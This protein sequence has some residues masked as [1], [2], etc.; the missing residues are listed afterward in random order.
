M[1]ILLCFLSRWIWSPRNLFVAFTV[2]LGAQSAAAAPLT[3]ICY[4][5]GA[6]LPNF[7]LNGT[8][9][10]DG[11]SLLVTPNDFTK[12]ASIMYI[13]KFPVTG[14][15]H[16]RL[17]VN[18][19]T[20]DIGPLA[21]ADGM[22]FVMHND[23]D[24][25]RALGDEGYA[26]GYGGDALGEEIS[27]SVV[28]EFDT[29]QNSEFT[30]AENDANHIGVMLNGDEQDHAALYNPP[31]TMQENTFYVW[32]DYIPYDGINPNLLVYV[33][34]DSTKPGTANIE[35]ILDLESV[36]GSQ[37]FYM[38]FT[39][40]T[41]GQRS[42]HEILEFFATN[43]GT[44][45]AAC[46]VDDDSCFGHP[47]GEL[48]DP[49]RHVCAQ[50]IATD[51]SQ[52][53]QDTP[54]CDMSGS[55]NLCADACDADF[56]EP[57]TNPCAYG[58]L[59]VCAFSGPAAGSCIVCDGNF[60]DTGGSGID[61]PC[62]EGA[63]TCTASGWCSFCAL[64]E[65]CPAEVC[66][67]TTGECVACDG[68]YAEPTTFPCPVATLPVC[69]EGT[70]HACDGDLDSGSLFE[71]SNQDLPYCE[72]SSGA[73]VACLDNTHCS[74]IT[75]YCNTTGYVC[76]ACAGD[77]TPWCTNPDAPQC[78]T[79]GS[80]VECVDSGDCVG[81][82]PACNGDHSCVQCIDDSTCSGET[83]ICD[84]PNNACVQCIDGGDCS[85]GTPV[86]TVDNMCVQC[87]DSDDCSGDTP[88][89]SDDNTCVQCTD[90]ST[91]SG[92]T[93]VCNV[94]NTC[95]G[96]VD[97]ND[98]SGE[99]P[100]CAVDNSCVQCTDSSDCSADAPVCTVGSYCVACEDSSDC[101]GNTPVCTLDNACVQCLLATDCAV[102][103]STC[104]SNLCVP[105]VPVVGTDTDDAG[106]V[107]P[108]P[109]AD[110]AVSADFEG[111]GAS[112]SMTPSQRA[113]RS[114]LGWL[115]AV[116]LFLIIRA[117]ARSKRYV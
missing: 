20:T 105:P 49:Q 71:C 15:V 38:G 72:L 45:E 50:C 94:D 69:N 4:Q 87:A 42:R 5:G 37:D 66:D 108:T 114:S 60:G 80:C 36:L 77:G 7:Q 58:S 21:G 88:A 102:S 91:C 43:D 61:Y 54:G 93:S 79:D 73:C 24:G 96:C 64:I 74:G 99:T 34:L 67:N 35:Y 56:G 3:D 26:I 84:V 59:P 48:C 106:V 116:G 12:N 9:M 25:D 76:E 31:F 86:C 90:N 29:F 70:C 101:S 55:T 11:V 47:N 100:V 83:P 13:P 92:D 1:R 98:C 6:I 109:D 17:T 68:G 2:L 111:G 65:D 95:V 33:S 62:S 44:P 103:G 52:C 23:P 19:T 18:I 46:C 53:V 51:T 14:E 97:S 40:S 89:C 107:H 117:R 81:E 30:P 63:P 32:I 104:E 8:A 39:G 75:P 112:C 82:T 113:A 57:G 28:V 85:G 16:V 27:P 110:V 78:N 41:G 115:L 22:A 10:L